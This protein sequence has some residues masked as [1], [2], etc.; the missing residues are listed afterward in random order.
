MKPILSLLLALGCA[1]AA[2]SAIAAQP[3]PKKINVLL[4]TGED[5]GVHP[6]REMSEATREVLAAGK[7]EVKVAEE[8]LILESAAALKNYDL[9]FLSYYNAKAPTLS[10]AAKENLLSFV[11]GGKGLAI[12]H[13]SSAS[14]KEWD[15]FRKMV[16]RYWVMGKSGH[17]PRSVFKAKIANKTDPITQGLEDFDQDDEL[18]AKMQGDA[19]I[20]VLVTADSDWSKQTEPLAF[21]L[22]YGQGRVFHEC[23]GHDGKAIKNPSV[24]RLIQRGCEWAAKGKVE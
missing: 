23:F 8:P 4:I 16:G 1:G 13:L 7:F 5:V 21:T 15:E 17:G 22:S 24:A 3:A 11:K 19:P 12:S 6:W 14:W 10:D 20:N 2:V 9:I 18:Y